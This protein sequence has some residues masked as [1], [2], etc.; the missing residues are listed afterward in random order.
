MDISRITSHL[1]IVDLYG[2]A[3]SMTSTIEGPFG[4]HL[5]VEGFML[6]NEL[7]DFSFLPDYD[8]IPIANRV[9]AEAALILNVA[10]NNL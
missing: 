9:E 1:V 8:G 4:S 2:N 7:T 10:N 3:I 5:M 6:N